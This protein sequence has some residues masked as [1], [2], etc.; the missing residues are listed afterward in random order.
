MTER[1]HAKKVA[2]AWVAT[3]ETH[4]RIFERE[5]LVA[6][7]A[8]LIERERADARASEAA[9]WMDATVAKT[10]AEAAKDIKELEARAEKAERER[11]EARQDARESGDSVSLAIAHCTENHEGHTYKQGQAGRLLLDSNA[12]LRA[13]LERAEAA[14]AQMRVALEVLR[15][16][17][18][19]VAEANAWQGLDDILDASDVGA[20]YMSPEQN[21]RAVAEARRQALEEAAKVLCWRC[22]DGAGLTGPGRDHHDRDN[23]DAAPVPCP[24]R[25]IR[26]LVKP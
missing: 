2:D 14:A 15:D 5:K 9:L 24:A 10:P 6:S 20:G 21:A 22:R 18:G 4:R 7:L 12:T 1:E 3:V 23:E 25:Q 16:A 13:K 17:E 19:Y 11:D 8:D 26:A